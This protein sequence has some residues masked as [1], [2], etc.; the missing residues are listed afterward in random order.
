MHAWLLVM[1][2]IVHPVINFLIN[3]IMLFTRQPTNSSQILG[4][5][6]RSQHDIRESDEK[7]IFN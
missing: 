6:C 5:F 4:P 7:A 3:L 2:I 1:M